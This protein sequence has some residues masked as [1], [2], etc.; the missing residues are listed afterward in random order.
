MS[1]TIPYPKFLSVEEVATALG[2]VP[3][4]PPVGQSPEAPRRQGRAPRS[5]TS[6][7]S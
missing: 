5:D 4:T 7:R 1:E 3:L 2:V 6:G